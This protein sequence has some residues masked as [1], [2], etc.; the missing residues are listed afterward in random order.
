MFETEFVVVRS[1]RHL[2]TDRFTNFLTGGAVYDVVASVREC[3]VARQLASTFAALHPTHGRGE[4]IW[5]LKHL[6][7]GFGTVWVR[8]KR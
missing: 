6:L 4:L 5:S 3:N 7:A 8:T 2:L 1:V